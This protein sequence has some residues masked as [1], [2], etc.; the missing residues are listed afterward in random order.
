MIIEISIAIAVFIFAVLAFFIIRTLISLQHTLRRFDHLSLDMEIKLKNVDSLLRTLSN[1]GDITEQK[2]HLIKKDYFANS[3]ETHQT[4]NYTE[5]L[6]EW[7]VSSIK[8]GSKLIN[9]R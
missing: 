7:L 1:I 6:S 8:L 5:D 9:R 3:E 2:T 4:N